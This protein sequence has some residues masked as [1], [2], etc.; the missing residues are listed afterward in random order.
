MTTLIDG[1]F[2][3]LKF[4]TA[5]LLAIMVVLVFGNV[6]L[7]YA[8]NSGITVSEELSRWAFVWLVF[9]GALVGLRE[10]AH[11][12]VDTLVKALPVRG[13]RF[14]YVLSHILMIYA[15]WLLTKGSWQQMWINWDTFAPASGFSMAWFYG[16]G[17]V[18]GVSA[19]GILA[20][21]LVR[22]LRGR[23]SDEELV[24]VRESEEL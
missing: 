1:Y 22:L 13:K 4:A 2:R 15:T 21:E 5:T 20:G 14:C 10:R 24:S 18:F 12:G 8:F 16:I 19:I 6:V 9:L 17:V 3:L 11:L 7:R 23:L